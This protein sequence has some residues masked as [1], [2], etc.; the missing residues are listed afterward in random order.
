LKQGKVGWGRGFLQGNPG[1]RITFEMQRNKISN[2]NFINT[3]P[4]QKKTKTKQTNNNNK[5]PLVISATNAISPTF[6]L[7]SSRFLGQ[8]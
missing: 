3:T 5:K 6:N 2:K 1:E 4:P 8:G 7:A